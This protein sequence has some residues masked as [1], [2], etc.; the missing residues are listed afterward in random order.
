MTAPDASSAVDGG[1]DHWLAIAEEEFVPAT[2]GGRVESL[3]LLTAAAAAGVRLHVIVPGMGDEASA[4]AHGVALPGHL[5][6]GIPRATTWRSHLSLQP[7]VFRSR[8]LPRGFLRHVKELHA[9]D[10]FDVVLAAS[11]RVAHLGQALANA[12]DVPLVIRP[13]NGESAYFEQLSH[14]SSF[15]RSLAYRAEAYKLRRAESN[16]HS[17]VDVALFADISQ[18]DAEWRAALTRRP[19]IHVP[20]FVDTAR[21][22]APVD[23]RQHDG[24][25]SSTLLFLGALDFPNNVAGVR[26]F[27]ERCWPDL[28]TREDAVALHIV[29]RRAPSRLVDE[30]VA[31]GARVTS[32][33]PEVGSLLSEADVFVNPMQRGSGVNI[34]MVEAMQAGLP[35]VSTTVGARGLSW[36]DGQHLLIADTPEQFTAA[37]GRLV[38]DRELRQRIGSAAQEFVRDEL[39]GLRHIGR[40]TSLTRQV[41]DDQG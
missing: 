20:P 11:F 25:V 41:C 9:E 26:W 33:A 8:P 32:N 17:A 31:C 36:R 19:V 34:K 28:R 27:V 15:P 30:L 38:D 4:A 13:L 2:S 29:G 40:M 1:R 6:E 21:N 5:L 18:S 22:G 37:V 12:I 14:G 7:Y 23:R 3:N 16:I 24:Q 10:P 35:I 39:D